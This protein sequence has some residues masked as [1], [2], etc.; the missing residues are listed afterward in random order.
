MAGVAVSCCGLT[1]A[2]ALG[3][4]IMGACPPGKPGRQYVDEVIDTSHSPP[5]VRAQEFTAWA[6][7]Q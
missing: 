7:W 3:V 4:A 5:P 6:P 1:P 2:E